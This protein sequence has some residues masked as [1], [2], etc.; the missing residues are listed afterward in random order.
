M[1]LLSVVF[2]ATLAFASLSPVL[3]QGRLD[4][5]KDSGQVTLGYRESSIPFS[6]L[7]G[8]QRPVGYSM[9][10]CYA[11]VDA[12]KAHLGLPELNVRQVPVTSS[13][14]IPLVANGTV[15]MTCG[16]ATNNAQRQEQVS[17]APTTFVTATRFAALKASGFKDLADLKGKTVVSTAGTSNLRWLTQANAEQ[18]LGLRI[19]T[20]KDHSEAFLM[21][22]SGRAAAFFMDDI[23]LAGLVANSRYADDWVISQKA[24]TIEPYGII[25]PRNDPEFKAVVDAAVK[26]LMQDGR[27]DA[28]YKKWFLQPIPPRNINMNWPMTPE[29]QRVIQNPTDSPDPAAYTLPAAG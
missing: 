11:I 1:K 25:L 16:S 2:A 28:L 24:Y 5:I 21:V 18:N 14:R 12:V 8:E 4:K 15:D 29:L 27:L 26:A 19:I 10:I 23:L 17:F 20:A 6:Y 9:D 13:T 3:A 7:D 22:S